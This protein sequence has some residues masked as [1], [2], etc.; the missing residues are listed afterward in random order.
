MKI[1]IDDIL[2]GN[3]KTS[4]LENPLKFQIDLHISTHRLQNSLYDNSSGIQKT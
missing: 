3:S 4:M 1:F 2:E